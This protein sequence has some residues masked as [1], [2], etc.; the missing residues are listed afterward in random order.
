MD[1]HHHATDRESPAR[2]GRLSRRALLQ[3][4]A[5]TGVGA[6]AGALLGRS[7]PRAQAAAPTA[8]QGTDWQ[9]FDQAVQAAMGHFDMVGTAVAVITADGTLHS[10]TFGFRDRASGAPV[11]PATLFRIGSATKSITSTLVATFVDDGTLGWDQPVVEVW[12]AFRAPTAELTRTLRV[13]DLM[14]MATGLGEP[15]AVSAHYDLP[16]ALDI[17]RAFADLPVLTPPDTEWYYN[18]AVYA[19]AGYLPLLRQGVA[20]SEWQ[21]VYAQLMQERV[22]GPAGMGTARIGDDPRPF[23]DDYATGYARDLVAGT[24]AEPWVPIGSYAP[25][26]GVLA[27]LPDMAAHVR[28]QLRRGVSPTGTRVVSAGNLA[29]CWQPHI[30]V[31]TGPLDGPD[32][33]SGR[34]AMG[35]IEDIYT[36]GRR[37]IWH[38]GNWD[39]FASYIG[40]FPEDNLGLAILENMSVGSSTYFYRYVLNLLLESQ[41]GLNRGA[42]DTLVAAYQEAAGALTALAR[43]ARPVDAGA[44]APFLGNYEH[45]YRLAYDGDGT[46]RLHVGGRALRVLALPEGDYVAASGGTLAGTPIR[47]LRDDMG[48]PML[49]LD[50]ESVH[51]LTGPG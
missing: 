32:L 42:N 24:A 10:Q 50:D 27:S 3:S 37:L 18:N 35:W 43:R 1:R 38:T 31:P 5:V 44:I 25:I 22:F 15:A 41:F 2:A 29:E 9:S 13:R 6:A 36:N 21:S 51:W 33:V 47:F 39:G 12:P 30:A 40:F 26:G 17:M 34:Y 19:V 28:L 4:A 49:E 7:A 23:T 14:G 46:L 20:A 48:A 8:S 16:S 45:A 11:T